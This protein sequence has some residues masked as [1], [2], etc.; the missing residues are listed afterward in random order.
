M[1]VQ[2]ENLICPGPNGY[3][4]KKNMAHKYMFEAGILDTAKAG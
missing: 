4:V 3:D 2:R 1:Q